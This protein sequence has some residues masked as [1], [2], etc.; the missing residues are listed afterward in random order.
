MSSVIN[1]TQVFATV[2]ANA[3]VVPATAIFTFLV[4][5]YFPKIWESTEKRFIDVFVKSL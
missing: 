4:M 2:L 5:R 1:W 3:I